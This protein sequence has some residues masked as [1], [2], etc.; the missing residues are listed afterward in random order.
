MII[1]FNLNGFSRLGVIKEIGKTRTN[2]VNFVLH[3]A[4]VV[5]FV[6]IEAW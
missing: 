5:G 2:E 4:T 3:C 6:I 1:N